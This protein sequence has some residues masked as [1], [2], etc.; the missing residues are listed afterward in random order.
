MKKI[1]FLLITICCATMVFAQYNGNTISHTIKKGETISTLA[2]LYNV[3]T[4][5]ILQANGLTDKTILKIGQIIIIPKAKTNVVVKEPTSTAVKPSAN[6][7]LV[8]SGET[9]SK[10]AKKYNV[11]EKDLKTWNNLS[12]DN[13]RAG[14]LLYVNAAGVAIIKPA[15]EEPVVK[16]DT[17]KK[18]EPVLQKSQPVVIE[19][20][21]DVAK[22]TPINKEPIIEKPKEDKKE[23]VKETPKDI[24]PENL[25]KGVFEGQYEGTNNAVEG[26]CGIFKTIAG[27]HDTKYYI[28]L[29]NAENGAVVK[30]LANNKFVYA[31]VLGPLPDIKE[32][33]N[34]IMRISNA[35]AAALGITDNKFNAKVEF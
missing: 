4:S 35:A 9:L 18:P 26:T 2:K 1:K 33:K 10:I 19:D 13:I 22:E 3:A 14:A 31:K 20:K 17:P 27:W 32:D 5:E 12:N 15:K 25:G 16:K 21:K 7:H 28:L 8:Q 11:T 34:V 24:K 29:N 23:I 30:V 6:Q